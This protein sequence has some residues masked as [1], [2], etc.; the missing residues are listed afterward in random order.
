MQ[1][2]H[3]PARAH[4]ALNAFFAIALHDAADTDADGVVARLAPAVNDLYAKTPDEGHGILT[5]TLL[6]VATEY[7]LADE[8]AELA[9]TNLANAALLQGLTMGEAE[10]D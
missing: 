2:T 7:E 4:R 10:P 6:R 8:M 9:L 5:A 1:R 3:S